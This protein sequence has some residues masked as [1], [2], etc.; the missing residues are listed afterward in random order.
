MVVETAVVA[1]ADVVAVIHVGGGV[2]AV[3]VGAHASCSHCF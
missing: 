1:R 3:A 2:V